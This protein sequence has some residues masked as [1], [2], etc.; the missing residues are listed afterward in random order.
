MG[1]R[2]FNKGGTLIPWLFLPGA[3]FSWGRHFTVTPAPHANRHTAYL[4][5]PGSTIDVSLCVFSLPAFYDDDAIDFQLSNSVHLAFAIC[6]CL[7]GQFSRE[8]DHVIYC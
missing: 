4:S 8:Q 7:V 2:Y 6:A 1:R 3:D 5:I